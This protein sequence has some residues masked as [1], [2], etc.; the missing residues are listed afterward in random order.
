MTK[1]AYPCIGVRAQGTEWTADTRAQ[2][3]Q[4]RAPVLA[5]FDRQM[6]E[7]VDEQVLDVADDEADIVLGRALPRFRGARRPRA[8]IRARGRSVLSGHRVRGAR[9]LPSEIDVPA[10][11]RSDRATRRRRN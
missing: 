7:L 8:A 5:R 2:A 10:D 4:N 11:R 9:D 1:D 3:H 6:G